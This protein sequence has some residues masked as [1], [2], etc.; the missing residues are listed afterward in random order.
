VPGTAPG[1]QESPHVRKNSAASPQPTTAAH[2]SSQE[3]S[4]VPLPHGP[5]AALRRFGDRVRGTFFLWPF[6]QGSVSPWILI[7]FALLLPRS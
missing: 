5:A 7:P 6:W 3:T 4:A 2:P 1:G